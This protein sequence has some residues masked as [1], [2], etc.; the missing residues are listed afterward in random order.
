[1]SIKN[2]QEAQQALHVYYARTRQ[3]HGDN[4]ALSRM[5]PLL[6]AVGSPHE[7]LKVVHVAG[8]SGK[9]STCYYLADL[10]HS[11]GHT[12]G[13]TVS[14]YVNTI[15]E[16]VQI[17]GRPIS[18][19]VFCDHLSAFLDMIQSVD[20][21]P[22]YFEV[23]IAFTLWFFD[24]NQVDY[25]VLETG[26]GGLYDS[27]NVIM[28]QDK[29]CVITDIGMD[30]MK[31]LGD[32]VDKIAA[33][34]AGIIQPKNAVFMYRQSAVVMNVIHS[35]VK[36]QNA[37]LHIVESGKNEL[38][39]TL[40]LYQQ[41]N[42]AL[43]FETV[44]S[45]ARRD[46]FGLDIA[47]HCS[48]LD[49]LI[50]GRMEMAELPNG[51]EIVFDGAHNAQKMSAFVSSFQAR[52]P[53]VKADVLVAFKDDKD[54]V[55]ALEIL[56]PIVKKLI[57]TTLSS[58]G[59][60][61]FGFEVASADPWKVFSAAQALSIEAEVVDSCEDAYRLLLASASAEKIVTGSLYLIGLVRALG[62]KT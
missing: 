29:I 46:G 48:P 40:P 33:Q 61:S 62:S 57:I 51:Q 8:T 16:R 22:G 53:E 32:S 24:K 14:P 54:Y 7:R 2:L 44:K 34:K 20:P 45:M 49:V 18:E 30:H 1:M 19:R 25:V 11:S 5:K 43:A 58:E 60:A 9:T 56:Q 4:S 26:I 15:L 38:S 13:L 23:L 36:Q 6:M 10:L 50:P 41:R 3:Q 21:Q 28:R 37:T 59:D 55:S 42:W 52:F 12:V 27:T 17:N 39:A 47:A 35:R 31:V